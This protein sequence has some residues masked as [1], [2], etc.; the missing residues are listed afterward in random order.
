MLLDHFDAMNRALLK[1]N[2]RIAELIEQQRAD[3]LERLRD[4]REA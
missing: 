2:E 1:S 3:V 4:R